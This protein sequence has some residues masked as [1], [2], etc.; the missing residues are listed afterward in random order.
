MLARDLGFAVANLPVAF[1]V[2]D[3]TGGVRELSFPRLSVLIMSSLSG[4][5]YRCSHLIT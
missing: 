2:T 4:D 1:L 5:V 3:A